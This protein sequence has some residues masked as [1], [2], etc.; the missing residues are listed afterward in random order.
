[1]SSDTKNLYVNT[2]KIALS[3]EWRLYSLLYCIVTNVGVGWT[4][5]VWGQYQ[6]S[7]TVPN[8]F[9]TLLCNWHKQNIQQQQRMKLF[10]TVKG[11]N[12]NYSL[13]DL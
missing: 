13:I 1:M 4:D 12:N 9:T 7:M 6:Q 3:V 5:L 10:I 2:M 8:M 11:G